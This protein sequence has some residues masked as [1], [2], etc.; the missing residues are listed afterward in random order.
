MNHPAIQAYKDNKAQYDADYFVEFVLNMANRNPQL[1][2]LRE[3]PEF[4]AFASLKKHENP[5]DEIM[6]TAREFT[7]EELD[8]L[9]DNMP[10]GYQR[11][12]LMN[13]LDDK[14]TDT[15]LSSKKA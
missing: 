3:T 10:S 12:R 14:H 8:W 5:F 13:V 11:S 15:L 9:I 4:K 1:I 2:A 6:K 7:V